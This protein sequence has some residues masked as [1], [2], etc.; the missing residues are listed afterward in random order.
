MKKR[1]TYMM[2]WRTSM[3]R[4][5]RWPVAIL[6]FIV[7]TCLLAPWL[8]NAL[9]YTAMS[10]QGRIYPL[11]ISAHEKIPY[12]T[13]SA[14]Y[15]PLAGVDRNQSNRALAP[16][17]R[18][19][20]SG[21]LHILGTTM[22]SGRRDLLSAILHGGRQSLAAAFFTLL[23]IAIVGFSIG[24]ISGY[25]G[26]HRM[27]FSISRLI[28]LLLCLPF[29][30]F[31]GLYIWRY[32]LQALAGQSL[33][34][35]MGAL[36]LCVMSILLLLFLSFRLSRMFIVTS[37]RK[38]YFPVDAALLWLMQLIRALPT[39][40]L[41]I[42]LT[43]ILREKSLILVMILIGLTGWAGTGLLVRGEV[44][45]ERNKPYIQAAEALGIPM[46]RILFRHLIPNIIGPLIGELLL[47]FSGI[48]VAEA[49]LSFLGIINEEMSWGTLINNASPREKIWWQALFPG[50]WLFATIVCL[51]LI[52]EY[53]RKKWTR[54][55]TVE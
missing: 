28:V 44:M 27:K 29:V 36:L 17:S 34:A 7:L 4:D 39:L 54:T 25:W 33:S 8:A 35:F 18:D 21:R 13:L 46:F 43:L 20:K 41:I 53:L 6:T 5:I 49:S 3:S 1:L 26:N 32:D 31:Y 15:T 48:I 24:G 22:R 19:S 12:D 42:T 38:R 23:I 45:R 2:R 51:Q 40:L 9:P 30:Y 37:A 52:G 11:F 55:S 47:G 16:M 10:E 14:I 50:I